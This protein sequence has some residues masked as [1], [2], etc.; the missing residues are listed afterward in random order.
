LDLHAIYNNRCGFFAQFQALWNRQ[1]NQG[2]VPD[3]PG[4]DFWQLN[5]FVGYRFPRRKAELM[6]GLLNIAN[7][8]YRLKSTQFI[9]GVAART[10]F[11]GALAIQFLNGSNEGKGID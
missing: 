10:D 1:S 8:D 4:D 7:Q 3:I 9:H 2:Y 6:I 5:V 11:D